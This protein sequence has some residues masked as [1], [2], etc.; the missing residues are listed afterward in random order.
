M[1]CSSRRSRIFDRAIDSGYRYANG[2]LEEFTELPRIAAEKAV[3]RG[4][5]SLARELARR[6][7]VRN[8]V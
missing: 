4:P 5:N 3:T 8:P 2:M 1:C 6:I 7:A